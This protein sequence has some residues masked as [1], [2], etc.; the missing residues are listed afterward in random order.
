M[1]NNN[2]EHEINKIKLADANKMAE[3]LNK[4][5]QHVRTYKRGA[6]KVTITQSLLL[7]EQLGLCPAAFAEIRKQYILKQKEKNDEK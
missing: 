1:E 6:T 5:V 7:E 3:I 2:L 4:S